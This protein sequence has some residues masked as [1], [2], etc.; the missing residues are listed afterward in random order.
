ME[1]KQTLVKTIQL[2]LL[3]KKWGHF[4]YDYHFGKMSKI[5][6]IVSC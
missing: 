2:T 6:T 3:A 5:I 4:I 1:N